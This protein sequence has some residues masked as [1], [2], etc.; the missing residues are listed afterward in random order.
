[1]TL[2]ILC[3]AVAAFAFAAPLAVQAGAPAGAPQPNFAPPPGPA[4][5]GF[6]IFSY[7]KAI[8]DSVV[9][10]V[11]LA[12]MQQLAAQV[13]AELTPERTAV[14]T[15]VN[16]LQTQRATL[17]ADQLQTRGNAVNA[18]IEAYSQKEQLR[19]QELE[20]TKNRALQQIVNAVN[21]LLSTVYAQRNCSV[22]MDQAAFITNNPAMDIS[23][24]VTTQLNSR[25][26]T[27]TFDRANLSQPT[28][29][30]ATAR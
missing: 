25:M 18:R 1:M 24:A 10:K 23:P 26:T 9:G 19:T 20:E 11:Y 5:G 28:P 7:D 12:R 4:I 13:Q 15:E 30:A 22:V 21:P 3:A 27:I 14:Q 29:G 17:P 6:C 16:T 8:G 2:K